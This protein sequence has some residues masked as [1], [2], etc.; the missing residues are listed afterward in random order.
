M[1]GKGGPWEWPMRGWRIGEASHPGPA[2]APAYS[3]ES[4]AP[5]EEEEKEE[6]EEEEDVLV[7]ML[8]LDGAEQF[9][10]NTQPDWESV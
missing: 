1:P 4:P 6:E 7:M 9:R 3:P 10:A 5:E 2:A 8:G